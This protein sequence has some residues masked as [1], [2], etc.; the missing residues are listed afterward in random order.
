[1]GALNL[2]GERLTSVTD[3]TRRTM[4]AVVVKINSTI[5][6][7]LAS[8]PDDD[9]LI[10]AFSALRSIS[11]TQCPGEESSL[12]VMIPL[13]L[14]IAPRHPIAPAAF[15]ALLSLWYISFRVYQILLL[16]SSYS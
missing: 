16:N 1:M 4:T 14:D 12:A 10:A 3:E 13:V 9:L 5:K 15:S 6:K 7:I 11:Q 8:N 2:L